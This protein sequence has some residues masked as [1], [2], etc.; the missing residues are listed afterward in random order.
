MFRSYDHPQAEI[1]AFEINSIDNGSVV[2][3]ILANLVHNGDRSLVTID[4]VVVAEL[5]IA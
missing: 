5:T 1:Y 4:V 2:L 3:R